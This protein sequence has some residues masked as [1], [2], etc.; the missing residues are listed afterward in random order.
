MPDGFD[1]IAYF[2]SI[3]DVEDFFD[4]WTLQK[5]SVYYKRGAVIEWTHE[6]DNCIAGLVQGTMRHPYNV[7][8]CFDREGLIEVECSCPVAFNCKHAAALMLAAI[9]N[10]IAQDGDR[11]NKTI[12]AP[13]SA[14]SSALMSASTSIFEK[15]PANNPSSGAVSFS[16][17]AADPSGKGGETTRNAQS[18]SSP[19]A[20]S[21]AGGD[22]DLPEVLKAWLKG[23]ASTKQ[24]PPALAPVRDQEVIYILRGN[25]QLLF[26][27][28]AVARR[29][30]TGGYGMAQQWYFPKLQ[31]SSAQPVT[32][33]DRSIAAL[34]AGGRRDHQWSNGRV[35]D[36]A[37]VQELVLK[38]IVATGRAF[39]E[40]KDNPPLRLGKKRQANISWQLQE[41]G[42]QSVV[43]CSDQPMEMFCCAMPWYVDTTSWQ[44]GPLETGIEAEL[45]QCLI[46][47]P[48]VE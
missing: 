37:E 25:R 5:G 4:S 1:T 15:S 42:T 27:D 39:F 19:T 41:D 47:A 35:P 32:D 18:G 7:S 26:V 40:S 43:L 31:T 11:Q 44:T 28:L 36:D 14:S 3:G 29:L 20:Q 17:Y 16:L 22:G 12:S 38:R 21:Q 10:R 34:F 30:K 2:P 23:T 8:V 33:D 45:L 46:T 13:G 24:E 9:N 6:N 48:P